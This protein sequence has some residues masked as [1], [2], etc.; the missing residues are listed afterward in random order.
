MVVDNLKHPDLANNIDSWRVICNKYDA[1]ATQI[2]SGSA[3][4]TYFTIKKTVY[5]N[6]ENKTSEDIKS[7]QVNSTNI[8][9]LI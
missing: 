5:L 6:D 3:G 4:Y 2:P 8:N 7:V 1:I 9:D